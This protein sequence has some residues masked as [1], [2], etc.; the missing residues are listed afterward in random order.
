MKYIRIGFSMMSQGKCGIHIVMSMNLTAHLISGG[1]RASLFNTHKRK[2]K[3]APSQ[4]QISTYIVC[5]DLLISLKCLKHY[6]HF[7]L[8]TY[9]N[10]ESF[11]FDVKHL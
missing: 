6:S 1:S 11:I 7:L 4:K 10:F 2:I 9:N 5:N 3:H 8:D